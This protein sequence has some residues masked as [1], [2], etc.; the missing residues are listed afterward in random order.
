MH[1]LVMSE[2]LRQEG[3]RLGFVTVIHL[4][5]VSEGAHY[6][7]HMSVR[8]TFLTFKGV[9]SEMYHLSDAWSTGVALG[10]LST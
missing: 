9:F 5:E 8:Y 10:V 7:H 2:H 3:A 4:R 1:H 6:N